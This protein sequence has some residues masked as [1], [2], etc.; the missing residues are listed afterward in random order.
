MAPHD[1]PPILAFNSQKIRVEHELR[2]ARFFFDRVAARDARYSKLAKQKI[3]DRARVEAS[4]WMY[5]ASAF[6]SATLSVYLYF[7][8]AKSGFLHGV[9]SRPL[10]S[11]FSTYFR[12]LFQAT[13][14]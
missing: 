7:D 1:P 5:L 2:E 6:I 12:T 10:A 9:S 4:E 13:R 3:W 8:F 11:E 14:Q